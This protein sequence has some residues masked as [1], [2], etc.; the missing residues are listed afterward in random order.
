M[1]GELYKD[2]NRVLAL[3]HSLDYKSLGLEGFGKESG[4]AARQIKTWTRNY[5]AQDEIVVKAAREEG[6]DWRPS[7]M[8]ALREQLEGLAQGVEEPTAIVHGDFRMGNLIIDPEKPKVAAVLD[9][10]LCTLGHPLVDVAWFCK[11][12]NWEVGGLFDKQGRLPRGVP[13]QEGFLQLYAANR[14]C[15]E[16]NVRDWDFFRALDCYRT[17]GINHGVYARSVMGNAASDA[18]RDSGGSLQALVDLG[19]HFASAAA[20]REQEQEQAQRS[21]L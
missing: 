16:V 15:P 5:R 6:I 20:S 2:I 10:E 12:W 18:L 21:K 4:F 14:G 1:R 11:P 9:W 13:S 19:L 17:V 7:R 8:E 3:L